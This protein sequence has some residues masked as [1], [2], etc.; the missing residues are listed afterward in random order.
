[1]RLQLTRGTNVA[2]GYR[3]EPV[4]ARAQHPLAQRVDDDL[5]HAVHAAGLSFDCCEDALAL[6]RA[7]LTVE[8]TRAALR[9]A[10][11]AVTSGTTM[12]GICIA[13]I[14]AVE[15][16]CEALKVALERLL[17]RSDRGGRH[18]HL[19]AQVLRPCTL[20]TAEH[21]PDAPQAL[22][23]QRPLP[24]EHEHRVADGLHGVAEFALK[25]LKTWL[26]LVLIE[27]GEVPPVIGR[28]QWVARSQLRVLGRGRGDKVCEWHALRIAEEGRCLANEL[29]VQ[30]AQPLEEGADAPRGPVLLH[31]EL[32]RT[33]RRK[34]PWWRR[35]RFFG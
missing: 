19:K 11:A 3:I 6:I 2:V 31:Y 13:Q 22:Q 17:E 4:P 18:C 5:V 34:R 23:R 25:P 1:M 21:F 7:L 30:V 10:A 16:V 33:P 8:Y 28:A 27:H 35:T 32:L 12:E 24:L 15:H 9:L 14:D 26:I 29:R 20:H